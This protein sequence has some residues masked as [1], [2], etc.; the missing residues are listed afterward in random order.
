MIQTSHAEKVP[1]Q[2]PKAPADHT[3]TA[4]A[5][6]PKEPADHTKK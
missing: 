2:Q 6:Q 1:A 3:K 4:P 5:Q